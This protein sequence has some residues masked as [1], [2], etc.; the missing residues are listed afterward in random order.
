MSSRRAGNAQLDGADDE[1][2]EALDDG[3]L[4][5]NEIRESTDESLLQRG[6]EATEASRLPQYPSS[7]A[8]LSFD[9]G[10]CS[11]N[12]VPHTIS[13]QFAVLS[14]FLEQLPLTSLLQH[15][16][17]MEKN[18]TL[19]LLDEL[20]DVSM[21]EI[22]QQKRQRSSSSAVVL[23][24]LLVNAAP[25][26]KPLPA[27]MPLPSYNIAP[28]SIQ[29]T[30][31]LAMWLFFD[32]IMGK[33]MGR[34]M[35]QASQTLFNKTELSQASVSWLQWLRLQMDGMLAARASS[36][37]QLI[38][39]LCSHYAANPKTA[40]KIR[41][42]CASNNQEAVERITRYAFVAHIREVYL[43][44]T[45]LHP[46]AHLARHRLQPLPVA[47]LPPSAWS[48]YTGTWLC[49][50]EDVTLK[51]SSRT[52]NLPNFVPGVSMLLWFWRQL[53]CVSLTIAS[54]TNTPALLLS[55]VFNR[56]SSDNQLSRLVLDNQPRWF[57]CLPSGESTNAVPVGGQLFG[58][59][60]AWLSTD[61][62]INVQTYSWPSKSLVLASS[63][64]YCWLW[65]IAQPDQNGL[66][67]GVKV[68]RGRFKRG[69]FLSM[70]ED[71]LSTKLERI[72]AWE[73]AYELLLDYTRLYWETGTCLELKLGIASEPTCWSCWSHSI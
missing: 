53:S 13:Q 27:A 5:E 33:Q 44:T 61:N 4:Y 56:S 25:A 39:V 70:D 16:G 7:Q 14:W 23:S 65:Q 42:L 43:S 15:V 30:L 62:H 6:M 73:P 24:R 54:E 36:T 66:C 51:S 19:A 38:H 46:N 71:H 37:E 9:I 40:A 17:L 67:V 3:G 58:D 63:C 22:I 10:L 28:K 26:T 21:A 68:E 11:D 34:F 45:G 55:S 52:T 60:I 32:K 35:Q 69:Q 20:Q 18:F 1:L 64:A 57:R 8:K 48:G 2:E 41:W 12:I 59:Y 31:D 29:H 72:D 47:S 49:M 50:M